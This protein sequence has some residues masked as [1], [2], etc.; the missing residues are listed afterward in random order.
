MIRISDALTGLIR[1]NPF[2]EFGFHHRLF[3]LTRLA[4]YLHPHL[5]AR[6]KKPVQVSAITMNLSR[7]QRRL[8]A[9]TPTPEQFV[10]QNVSINSALCTATYAKSPDIHTALSALSGEIHRLNGFC[11]LAQGPHEITIIIDGR[12]RPLLRQ[13]VAAAPLY[14][15]DRIASVAVQFGASYTDVPGMLYMLLQ[16]V[17]LQNVNLIEI[18]STYTEIIFFVDESDTQTIFDAFYRNFLVR[19]DSR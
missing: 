7:L 1:G 18:A 13:N 6:T 16:C 17:A 11:S 4:N 15:H 5:E 2:L 10:I 19:R 3:N 9:T 14:D 12:Y 8:A